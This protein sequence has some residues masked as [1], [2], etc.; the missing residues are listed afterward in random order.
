[1]KKEEIISILSE[2]NFWG[3]GLD[4]GRERTLYLDRISGF[5]EGVE[6][7]ISVYGMRRSARAFCSGRGIEPWKPKTHK[8]I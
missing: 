4:T 1:M 7:V 3:K 2:W 8:V 5:L 6:K